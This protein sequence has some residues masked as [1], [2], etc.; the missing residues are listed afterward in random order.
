MILRLV[1]RSNLFKRCY[2]SNHPSEYE[3]DPNGA[4]VVLA[5]LN[6]WTTMRGEYFGNGRVKYS[7]RPVMWPVSISARSI[8]EL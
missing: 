4:D 1:V 3:Y 8:S 5:A 2:L 7:A 6:N